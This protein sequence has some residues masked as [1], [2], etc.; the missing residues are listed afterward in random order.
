MTIRSS[1]DGAKS[2]DT[3]YLVWAGPSAYSQLVE[4]PAARTAPPEDGSAARATHISDT[5]QSQF[6]V[7]KTSGLNRQRDRRLGLL[8]EA[9]KHSPYETISFVEVELQY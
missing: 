1:V 3:G 2:W 9:G 5:H 6:R 7:Y 8:F 4:L